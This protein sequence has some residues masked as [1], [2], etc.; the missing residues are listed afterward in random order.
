MPELPI[1]SHI[2]RMRGCR[3]LVLTQQ[4]E[5]RQRRARLQ[6][7]KQ[8]IGFEIWG[9]D[10]SND[11][12]SLNAYAMRKTRHQKHPP[13]VL[14]LAGWWQMCCAYKM[15]PCS[16]QVRKQHAYK[17][18]YGLELARIL[19]KYLPLLQKPSW[20]CLNTFTSLQLPCL[21][22]LDALGKDLYLK[23]KRMNSVTAQ[24]TSQLRNNL[25][26]ATTIEGKANICC[27][28]SVPWDLSSS[29]A[30]AKAGQ[31]NWKPHRPLSW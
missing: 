20:P 7:S 21:L 18:Y 12:S 9:E 4:P 3:L 1:S 8:A 11:P 22:K 6:M 26:D 14:H 13:T 27:N 2:N 16:S 25:S 5:K 23:F 30:G 15:S 24:H 31:K 19:C 28:P 29:D 17:R 10:P